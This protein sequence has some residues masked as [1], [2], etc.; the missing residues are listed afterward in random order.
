MEKNQKITY[1]L[2]IR[3]FHLSKEMRKMIYLIQT[4]GKTSILLKL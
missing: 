1:M 4:A 2:L 3:D